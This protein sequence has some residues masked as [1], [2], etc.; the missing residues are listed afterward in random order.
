[1]PWLTSSAEEGVAPPRFAR[2]DDGEM[3]CVLPVVDS[4]SLVRELVASGVRHVQ[5]RI[6]DT[7]PDAVREAVQEAQAACGAP[8]AHQPESAQRFRGTRRRGRLEKSACHAR[9]T[10]LRAVCSCCAVAHGAR[11]WVNDHWQAAV[12]AGVYG[13][14]VGQ[15]DLAAMD[16]EAVRALARSGARLGVSTHSYGELAT[17]L[18]VRPSYISLGPIYATDSKDVSRWEPQG[19]ERIAHWRS[20]LPLDTPLVAIGGVSL[21]RA[22]GVL[23][24]G[25]DGIAVISAI[26]KASDRNE[27]VRQWTSLWA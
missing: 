10:L 5:L 9:L 16:P 8:D 3:R 27:A 18:S 12:A 24:A 25:A 7:S 20:L 6:K 23:D 26:T 15:E 1:M 4:A 2:C 19:L 11:L 22:P 21:E 14:H 13:V 17:A